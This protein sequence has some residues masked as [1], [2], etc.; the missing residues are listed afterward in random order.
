MELN[1]YKFYICIIYK[2]QT[3]FKYLVESPTHEYLDISCTNMDVDG[4]NP[5][6][7]LQIKDDRQQAIINNPKEYYISIVKFEITTAGSLPLMIPEVK[8]NQNNPNLLNYKIGLIR[9]AGAVNFMQDVI[10]SPSNALTPVPINVPIN[11]KDLINPYYY[12]YTFQHFIRMLNVSLK[13][14]AQTAGLTEFPYFVYDVIS[15]LLSLY[16]PTSYANV[17]YIGVDNNL[18][19]ILNGFDFIY[20]KIISGATRTNELLFYHIGNGINEVT[21]DSVQ[22]FKMEQERSSLGIVNAVRGIE[23]AVN[24]LNV[25]PTLIQPTTVFGDNIKVA[26]SGNN[27]KIAAVLSDFSLTVSPNN[28]YLPN[29]GYTPSAEYRLFDMVSNTPQAHIMFDIYWK[30]KFGVMTPLTL[31]PGCSCNIKVMFRKKNFNGI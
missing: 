23:F 9:I 2:M 31:A 10:Y 27:A 16:V 19:V 21:I 15:G 4:D 6:P 11:N 14:S 24:L 18:A 7:L 22:Y 1:F 5:L 12:V 29:I 26:E 25:N 17:Y 28:L 3:Q 30:D 13:D 8:L 20:N